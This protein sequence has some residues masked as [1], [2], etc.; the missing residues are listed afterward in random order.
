MKEEYERNGWKLK[1]QEKKNNISSTRMPR[2]KLAL[3]LGFHVFQPVLS[4]GVFDHP[5]APPRS[6]LVVEIVKRY[7]ALPYAL[8]VLDREG[9]HCLACFLA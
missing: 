3:N 9:R 1:L 7:P 4:N 8:L 6:G 5:S 2:L